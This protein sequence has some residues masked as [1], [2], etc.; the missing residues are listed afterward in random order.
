M[1]RRAFLAAASGQNLASVVFV[2]RMNRFMET[3][4][5][6]AEAYNTGLFD[7]RGA[8]RLSKLWKDIEDSGNW[9]K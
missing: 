9:P 7:V 4:R 5:T 8:K 6:W 3:L 2:D 1:S